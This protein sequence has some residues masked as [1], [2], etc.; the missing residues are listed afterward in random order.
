MCSVLF[1]T[2]LVSLLFVS[3]LFLPFTSS[4]CTPFFILF[5]N[6]FLKLLNDVTSEFSGT[7]FFLPKFFIIVIPVEIIPIF[8][9]FDILECQIII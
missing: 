9:S 3:P 5:K 4:T 1:S 2:P 6:F 8:I 7:R